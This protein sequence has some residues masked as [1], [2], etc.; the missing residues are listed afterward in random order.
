MSA[1][2]L[3]RPGG[4]AFAIVNKL[5]GKVGKNLRETVC[6]DV[7]SEKSV[8]ARIDQGS[9][10]ATY[11][12]SKIELVDAQK[13]GV[14][15][16][17][18][19]GKV[20]I[21]AIQ[22][23]VLVYWGARFEQEVFTLDGLH[24]DMISTYPFSI[25]RTNWF[26]ALQVLALLYAMSVPPEGQAQDF[27][28]TVTKTDLSRTTNGHAAD[29]S[30][31]SIATWSGSDKGIAISSFILQYQAD[32]KTLGQR[33][34]LSIDPVGMDYK[35]KMLEAWD[36]IIFS[37]NYQLGKWSAEECVQYLIDRVGHEPSA[38]AAEVRRSIMG[39]Y[40]PLYQ[41]GYMLGGLQLRALHAEIVQAGKMNNREF[42]D[43]IL[44]ENYI[45]FELLR[46]KMLAKPLSIEQLPV[47]K[48]HTQK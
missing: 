28:P 24:E 19:F 45:P 22:N 15:K 35:T 16:R 8:A 37:L 43:A 36:R 23:G 20:S 30:N 44:K 12:K 33:F 27:K 40:G 41:A 11:S 9:G 32:Q 1:V 4:L 38:A 21:T 17:A 7:N 14:R 13:T 10:D 42:H 2:L 29:G 48:F 25:F 18:A 5:L 3:N 34:R 46:L 26:N 31:A 6:T 47:W 39:G